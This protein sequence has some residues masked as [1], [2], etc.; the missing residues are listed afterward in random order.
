MAG[1]L[2]L[3]VL[4]SACQSQP[5]SPPIP[6]DPAAVACV[7]AHSTPPALFAG[8][9]VTVG[10]E[11]LRGKYV[12]ACTMLINPRLVHWNGAVVAKDDRTVSIYFSGGSACM[13]ALQRVEATESQS[14]VT[15]SV[16][17]GVARILKPDS[18]F[19]CNAMGYA[20]AT[21]VELAAPLAA[22][23][24]DTSWASGTGDPPVVAHL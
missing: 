6:L 12:A 19:V 18:R 24:I 16:Y 7:A 2:P 5:G 9:T 4:V 20:N 21:T 3:I 22:R 23:H 10:S 8:E 17:L 11:V 13:G 1:C 15:L 14:V